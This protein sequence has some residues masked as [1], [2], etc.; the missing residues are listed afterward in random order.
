MHRARLTESQHLY[1][2]ALL[3][4]CLLLLCKWFCVK[5]SAKR[6]NV[7]VIC[8]HQRHTA[9]GRV[10]LD[11]SS[12]TC[13]SLLRMI[14]WK[15][16]SSTFSETAARLSPRTLALR[17]ASNWAT[18]YPNGNEASAI[19][20]SVMFPAVQSDRNKQQQSHNPVRAMKHSSLY[21]RGSPS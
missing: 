1:I 11:H 21:H 14:L 8:V 2:A 16:L 3:L 9:T 13:F 10:P 12:L 4:V 19:V 5:A 7:N 15:S 20:A 6:L 18:V 17:Q